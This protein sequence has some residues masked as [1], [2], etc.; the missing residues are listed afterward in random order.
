MVAAGIEQGNRKGGAEAKAPCNG[1][2]N[3]WAQY[4][5]EIPNPVSRRL[6]ALL[7]P[8]KRTNAAII[9]FALSVATVLDNLLNNEN[10]WAYDENS[11][12]LFRTLN[13]DGVTPMFG[14]T[15]KLDADKFF[16]DSLKNREV[17]Q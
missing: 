15:D 12:V 9:F 10:S 16:R 1:I 6:N 7:G 11:G 13:N 5:F 2:E 14:V 4:S 8:G 17:Q 3:P